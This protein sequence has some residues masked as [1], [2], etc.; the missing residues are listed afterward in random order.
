VEVDALGYSSLDAG[1]GTIKI[2]EGK[3]ITANNIFTPPYID[4]Y[5]M[6]VANIGTSSTDYTGKALLNAGYVMLE[7]KFSN[8][9]KL[10]WG[11]RLKIM[12]RN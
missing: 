6:V 3:G 8:K 2:P 11:A 4:Q 10:T 5:R 9:I 12:I 1:F 7:N